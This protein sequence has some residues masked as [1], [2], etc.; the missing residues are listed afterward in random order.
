MPRRPK[1]EENIRSLTKLA[2]GRSFAITLPLDLVRKW[3][4]DVRMELRLRVDEK[5]RQIIIE[6]KKA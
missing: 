1:A 6:K 3:G 5:T 2:G 4:W